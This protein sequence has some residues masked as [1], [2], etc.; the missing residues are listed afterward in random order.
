MPRAGAAARS[1]PH[2]VRTRLLAIVG[3]GAVLLL[4][5]VLVWFQPQKLVIN[6]TV[7]EALPTP[8]TSGPA[9]RP[10]T[11]AVLAASNLHSGEHHTVGRVTVLQLPD[12]RRLVRLTDFRTSNGPDV[13]VWLSA[14]GGSASNGTVRH[15][16]HTDLGGLKGNIGNQ[17]Y[18][19]PRDVDLADVHSLVIWCRRF[20]VTFGAAAL[21]V[22]VP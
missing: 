14:A 13:R 21:R 10:A 22:A 4:A 12:G 3:A 2:D 20:H 18:A 8:V 7:N 15:A 6:D 5:V 16:A 17:N 9:E 11:T 1:G 19:I